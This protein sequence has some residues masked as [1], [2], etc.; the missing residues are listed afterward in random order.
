MLCDSSVQ[1][2]DVL[3]NWAAFVYI[4]VNKTKSNGLQNYLK[5]TNNIRTDCLGH[6]VESHLWGIFK[7][8]LV[9]IHPV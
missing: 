5:N 9:T 1:V 3:N 7:K 6:I 4:S 8:G 2:Q